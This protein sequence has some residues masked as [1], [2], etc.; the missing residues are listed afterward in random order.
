[1][2]SLGVNLRPVYIHTEIK[3][4]PFPALLSPKIPP[5]SLAHRCS[6]LWLFYPIRQGFYQSSATEAY[7][8]EKA[9][10]E[11]K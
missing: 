9:I 5:Y 10:E 8:Q 7:P 6:F 3:G 1:M 11:K 2:H 4:S